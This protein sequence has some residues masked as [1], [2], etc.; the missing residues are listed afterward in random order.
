MH[1]ILID[2]WDQTAPLYEIQV[3]AL[4]LSLWRQSTV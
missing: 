1:V 3:V 4:F 2:Q